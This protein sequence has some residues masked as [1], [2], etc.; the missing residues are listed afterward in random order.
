MG[1]RRSGTSATAMRGPIT[2]PRK[3]R[4][5]GG[6]CEPAQQIINYAFYRYN[7][8]AEKK[9]AEVRAGQL[10]FLVR[11]PELAGRIVFRLSHGNSDGNSQCSS[12]KNRGRQHGRGLNASGGMR[13]TGRTAPSGQQIPPRAG[14]C[15]ELVK[16]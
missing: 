11:G 15:G 3:G 14:R 2:R 9:R 16:F 6:I 13:S 12:P 8:T 4:S 7:S 1:R 5:G 10:P